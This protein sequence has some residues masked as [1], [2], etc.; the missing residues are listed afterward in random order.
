MTTP[1]RGTLFHF[2]H[3][4]NLAS[5]VAE[6][7]LCDSQVAVG[8]SEIVE[9]A[10]THIKERRRR[11]QVDVEPGGCVADYAP[12]YLAARSPMLYA[13][14]KGSVAGY[15]G[16]QDEVVY[17][18]STVERLGALGLPFVFTDR[19]AVLQ[20]ARFFDDA[21]EMESVI[22]WK[23]MEGRRFDNTDTQIDRKERRMAEVLVHQ[24]C[25]W[26][27]ITEVAVRTRDRLGEV[28]SLLATLDVST[29]VS[30]RPGW[31]F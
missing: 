5:I 25:P 17:L 4:D 1:A 6:G 22:D 8:N 12:F 9:V 26:D 14:H 18:V 31:Y 15:L 30:A 13:I 11:R 23:V 2:T 3:I 21:A 20:F 16:G 27:A 28:S 29:P 10:H 7:L 19:N 24:R